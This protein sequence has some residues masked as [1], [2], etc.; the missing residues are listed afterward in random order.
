MK[1]YLLAAVAALALTAP[2]NAFSWNT[3]AA[4]M[5]DGPTSAACEYAQQQHAMENQQRQL[6][7]Q[8]R[9]RA[10]WCQFHRCY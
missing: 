9:A 5:R 8:E 1:K 3:E 7:E 4:C 2:A 10:Q 6:E